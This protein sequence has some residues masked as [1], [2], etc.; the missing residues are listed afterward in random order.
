[1]LTNDF[2]QDFAQ[3][4]R[5]VIGILHALELQIIS[6]VVTDTFIQYIV[7]DTAGTSLKVDMVKDVPFHF[8]SLLVESG[9]QQFAGAEDVFLPD[10][11]VEC[12]RRQGTGGAHADGERGFGAASHG[13]CSG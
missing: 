10:V 2:G 9:A 6:Q 7:S 12:A 4:N 13:L 5:A 3:V 11:F 8:G 1:M